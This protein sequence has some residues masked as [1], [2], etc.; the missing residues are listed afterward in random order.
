MIKLVSCNSYEV[1]DFIVKVEGMNSDVLS[2]VLPICA[3]MDRQVKQRLLDI[4]SDEELS[5]IFTKI[6]KDEQ[7]TS[8]EVFRLSSFSQKSDDN[9]SPEEC[10]DLFHNFV[11]C[12]AEVKEKESG[13]VVTD[14]FINEV[15]KSPKYLKSLSNVIYEEYKAAT[16]VAPSKKI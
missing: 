13:E 2:K 14:D 9:F 15:P 16:E 4:A 3:R 1:G 7:L 11:P 10:Q 12:I 6:G 8:N 5:A